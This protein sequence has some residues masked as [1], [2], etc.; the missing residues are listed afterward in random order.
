[1]KSAYAIFILS[2]LAAFPAALQIAA[3]IARVARRLR[4]KGGAS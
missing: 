3:P 2:V 1:M 4:E